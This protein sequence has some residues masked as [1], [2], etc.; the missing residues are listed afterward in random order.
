[1]HGDL[2]PEE[3]HWEAYQELKATGNVLATHQKLQTLRAEKQRERA[4]VVSLL[5]N[6]QVDAHLF[7]VS[8]LWRG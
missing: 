4:Y 1:M 2:S 5:E 7:S 3:V 6:V 8:S